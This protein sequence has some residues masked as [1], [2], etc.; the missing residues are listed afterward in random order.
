MAYLVPIGWQ[1]FPEWGAWAGVTRQ[2]LYTVA[3]ISSKVIYGVL[4]T[5]AAQNISASRQYE[6]AQ[7]VQIGAGQRDP[8]NEQTVL[9]A[10]A[11]HRR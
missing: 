3:D 10:P 7:Q 6:P 2:F 11:N 1:L 9:E 5:S 4:L 8:V